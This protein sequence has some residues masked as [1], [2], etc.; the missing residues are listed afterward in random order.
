[1][2]FGFGEEP[3]D[4][5]EQPAEGGGQDEEEGVDGERKLL[6][7]IRADDTDIHIAVRL[8]PHSVLFSARGM[9]N[10]ELIELETFVEWCEW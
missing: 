6:E 7:E 2:T 1:M 3:K 5:D 8:A 9:G 10:L 4:T